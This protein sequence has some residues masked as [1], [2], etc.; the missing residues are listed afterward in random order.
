M[1]NGLKWFKSLGV[2]GGDLDESVYLMMI[3]AFRVSI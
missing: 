1:I 2:I 3:R